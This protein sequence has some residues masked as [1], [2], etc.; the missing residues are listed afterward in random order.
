MAY[1]RM[2]GRGG[3]GFSDQSNLGFLNFFKREPYFTTIYAEKLIIFLVFGY[4]C[5]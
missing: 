1:S 4:T 5:R 2:T 3:S